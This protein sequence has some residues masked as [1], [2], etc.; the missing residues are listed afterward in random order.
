MDCELRIAKIKEKI[1]NFYDL[2]LWHCAIEPDDIPE[3][4]LAN[5]PLDFKMLLKSI[6]S[7]VLSSHPPKMTG[8]HVFSLDVP[9]RFDECNSDLHIIEW[10]DGCE[11]FGDT[12]IHIEDVL[13][14][15]HD[16][17]LTF[18]GYD[19][20][21]I[22]YQFVVSGPMQEFEYFKDILSFIE[23]MISD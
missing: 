21:E 20:R 12:E 15:G 4:E 7:G 10:Y 18:Y 1:D 11:S 14:V 23:T 8:Y 13:L 3:E 2:D 16:V 5:F 9:Y 19:T 22:P 17:E 6:G